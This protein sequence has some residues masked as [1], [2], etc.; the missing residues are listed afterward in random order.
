MDDFPYKKYF[1]KP[2]RILLDNVFK[3]LNDE[4]FVR[5]YLFDDTDENF[6]RSSPGKKYINTFDYKFMDQNLCLMIGGDELYYNV[7]IIP[8]LYI[9]DIRIKSRVHD[10][11]SP[12]N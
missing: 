12:S 1:T 9:E 7:D 11:I 5:W 4:T 10:S 2:P 3:Y 8:D 6:H